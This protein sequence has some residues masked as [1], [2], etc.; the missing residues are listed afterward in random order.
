MVKPLQIRNWKIIPTRK[1]LRHKGFKHFRFRVLTM[2]HHDPNQARYHLRYTR[3]FSFCYY[4]TAQAKIKDFPVCG[5][6]CGQSRISARFDNPSKSRKCPCFKAFRAYAFPL[7]D[8]VR[9]TP[10]AGALPT[11]LH[12]EIYMMGLPHKL[13]LLFY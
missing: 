11:A 9:T 5:H 2:A 8:S 3:I 4:T 6:S 12:P 13:P 7:V 1:P 10:K